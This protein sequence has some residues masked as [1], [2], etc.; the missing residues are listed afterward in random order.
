MSQVRSF[1]PV[2]GAR[3]RVLILGSMPGKRSLEAGEYYALPQNSFWRIMSGLFGIPRQCGYQARLQRLKRHDIA[4]WDVLQSCERPGS[5]DSSIVDASVIPN[6]FISFFRSHRHIE[7]VFFNGAKAAQ[8]YQRQVLPVVRGEFPGIRYQ[9][10]P[11]T[12]PAHAALSYEQK[13]EHWIRIK[14]VIDG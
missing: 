14:D 1:P 7:C 10:L 3:A 13:L 12:S 4:L 6:D 8:V 11:S 9:R 5:L 2:A